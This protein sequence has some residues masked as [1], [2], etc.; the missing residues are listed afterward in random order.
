[1]A[2]VDFTSLARTEAHASTRIRLLGMAHL[3]KGY[4]YREVAQFLEVHLT[5]VQGWVRRF[6]VDGI[7]G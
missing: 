5:T 6:A 4:T 3:N 7:D 2:T 1:M